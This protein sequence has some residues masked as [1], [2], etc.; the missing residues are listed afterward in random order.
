[1]SE[2]T[3]LNVPG[4]GGSGPQHWQTLWEARDPSFRRVE[5][6]DWDDPVLDEWLEVLEDAVARAASPVMLVAH[7]LGVALVNHWAGQARGRVRGALL[8]APADVDS[9]EHPPEAQRFGPM[10]LDPLPFTSI[11]VAS[12]N[13]FY[14][15]LERARYF[16]DCWGSRFVDV[17]ALGHINSDSGLGAWD[18]GFALLNELLQDTAAQ[19]NTR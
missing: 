19:L 5:Q 12:Q 17:G 3:V 18:T 1:M 8:V 2:V 11:V 9:K 16:A 14:V 10:P 15:S 6:G 4:L 13:D 7:S